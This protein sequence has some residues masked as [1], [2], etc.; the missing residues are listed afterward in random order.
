MNLWL[1]SIPLIAA[2]LGW[3]CTWMTV[4]LLF[5]PEQPYRFGRFTFQGIFPKHQQ[6][7]ADRIGKLAAEELVTP[8]DLRG[9][10]MGGNDLLSMKFFI[11]EKVDDYLINRFPIRYPVTSVFFGK[12]RREKIKADLLEEVDRMAPDVLERI[13]VEMENK[14]DIEELVM[15]KVARVTPQQLEKIFYDILKKEYRMISWIG[16]AV[17]LLAGFVQL[18]IIRLLI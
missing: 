7:L 3:F 6:R 2:L 15:D 16:A 1:Y 12:G 18:L 11:E 14:L 8:D 10:M 4:V 5:K 17:G 13:L 9:R